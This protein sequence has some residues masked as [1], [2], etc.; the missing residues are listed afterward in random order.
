[1]ERHPSTLA[2]SELSTIFNLQNTLIAYKNELYILDRGRNETYL[3]DVTAQNVRLISELRDLCR[4]LPIGKIEKA[5]VPTTTMVR[6]LTNID[7]TGRKY[8]Y[9]CI[10]TLL[11]HGAPILFNDIEKTRKVLDKLL[12]SIVVTNS[13][14]LDNH[15]TYAQS[16]VNHF[17]LEIGNKDSSYI[18]QFETNG[19]NCLDE[20]VTA[21][22]YYH[23]ENPDLPKHFDFLQKKGLKLRYDSQSKYPSPLNLAIVNHDNQLFDKLIDEQG[24]QEKQKDSL[25]YATSSDNSY[26]FSKLTERKYDLNSKH[27][28]SVPLHYAIDEESIEFLF[29]LA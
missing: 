7:L 11:K 6:Q 12:A 8:F 26:A 20:W 17:R 15:K 13:D 1:M 2:K 9:N 10:S 14:E 21:T 23:M 29:N 25:H 4:R 18:E 5:D 24:I 19:T 16:V 28:G 22:Y 3:L 27:E